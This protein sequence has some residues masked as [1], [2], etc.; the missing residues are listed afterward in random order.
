LK[1]LDPVSRLHLID[2]L[3]DQAR[4]IL[5][6]QAFLYRARQARPGSIHTR[7]VTTRY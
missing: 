2:N 3:L 6:V 7:I 1:H 5:H 4:G